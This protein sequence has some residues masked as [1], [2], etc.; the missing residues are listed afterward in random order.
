MKVAVTERTRAVLIAHVF[1]ARVDM[2]PIIECK[3]L[4]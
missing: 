1:G 3:S 2:Q 4:L